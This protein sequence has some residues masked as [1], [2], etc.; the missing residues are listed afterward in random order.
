[1]SILIKKSGNFVIWGDRTLGLDPAF[2]FKHQRET[3]SH[4]E[5]TF[6]E[7][8]DFIIFALNNSE[9]QEQLKSAFVAFFTPEFA[10]G[11]IVGDSLTD[12]VIIKIDAEN[13]TLITQAA[14]DLNAELG[15]RI[16]DT[17][18]RFIITISKL[19]ITETT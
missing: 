9:T 5:N 3:L 19:G 4:Y 14:G 7:N 10:K 1:M 2:K 11:A 13:N 6:L 12:A 18:E 8:F 15:V 16:V 17:V